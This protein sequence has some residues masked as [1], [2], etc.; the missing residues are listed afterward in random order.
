[1]RTKRG[2]TERKHG[3]CLVRK[4]KK[5]GKEEEEE[6]QEVKQQRW[7]MGER[8]KWEMGTEDEERKG[9]Q[10]VRIWGQET[11]EGRGFCIHVV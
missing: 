4:R 3:D 6:E 11:K 9:D 7:N 5:R 8:K 2:R 1:M 10:S